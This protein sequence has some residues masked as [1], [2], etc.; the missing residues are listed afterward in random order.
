[1]KLFAAGEEQAPK[2][3]NLEITEQLFQ[4]TRERKT[5]AIYVA[6]RDKN[7]SPGKLE[8]FP[9]LPPVAGHV[10]ASPGSTASGGMTATTAAVSISRT[11]STPKI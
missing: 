2:T 4:P 1:V 10:V 6:I 8:T 9:R 7:S 5:Q 3:G 11:G